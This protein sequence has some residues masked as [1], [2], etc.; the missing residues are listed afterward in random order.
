MATTTSTSAT[1]TGPATG[2][3]LTPKSHKP[4]HHDGFRSRLDVD[5]DDAR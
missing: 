5:K 2:R 1:A 3:P 4:L